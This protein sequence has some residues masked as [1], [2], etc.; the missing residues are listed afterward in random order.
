MWELDEQEQP[1]MV[2]GWNQGGGREGIREAQATGDSG[3][4]PQSDTEQVL[5][6]TP[7]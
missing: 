5:H 7:R 4:A 2:P 6:E 3:T 1:Q